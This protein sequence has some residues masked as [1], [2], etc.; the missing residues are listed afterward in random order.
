MAR[1]RQSA[2]RKRAFTSTRHSGAWILDFQPLE[3]WEI[4]VYCIYAAQV[5]DFVRAKWPQPPSM[6][7][8]MLFPRSEMISFTS[9][10][11]FPCCFCRIQIT[12]LLLQPFS[13]FPS[14]SQR[15]ISLPATWSPRS[16][17]SF[18][19]GWGDPPGQEVCSIC[20][21][22]RSLWG[23]ESRC[24]PRASLDWIPQALLLPQRHSAYKPQQAP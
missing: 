19:S 17:P 3:W 18:L 16:L 4:H 11:F 12:F 2:T 20:L 22:S 7:L 23:Q 5:W 6:L 13:N 8:H 24:A 14:F 10:L 21:Y 15:N 1:S 9:L